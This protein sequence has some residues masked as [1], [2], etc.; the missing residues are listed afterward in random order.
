VHANFLERRSASSQKDVAVRNTY[1][2]L[3]HKQ[4][5]REGCDHGT[6]ELAG[7]IPVRRVIRD[8]SPNTSKLIM[9]LANCQSDPESNVE[10]PWKLT[11]ANAVAQASP[12]VSVTRFWTFTTQSF[13]SGSR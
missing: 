1:L 3:E 7:A 10:F 8:P 5:A 6:D 4:R 2:T 12:S 9:I 13:I 11:S